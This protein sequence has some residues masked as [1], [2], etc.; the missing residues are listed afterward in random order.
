MLTN[1]GQHNLGNQSFIY[2]RCNTCNLEFPE[3]NLLIKCNGYNIYDCPWCSDDPPSNR[4]AYTL[5]DYF[6]MIKS[7]YEPKVREKTVHSSLR[8]IQS[9]AEI[10]F[11]VSDPKIGVLIRTGFSREKGR[12]VADLYYEFPILIS[13]GIGEVVELTELEDTLKSKLLEG[14]SI[15]RQ[16]GEELLQHAERLENEIFREDLIDSTVNEDLKDIEDSSGLMNKH[17]V[18]EEGD[19]IGDLEANYVPTVITA[20]RQSFISNKRAKDIPVIERTAKRRGRQ[21]DDWAD[22]E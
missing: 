4:A 8:L 21:A 3:I 15:C 12:I 1:I 14:A 22:L 7:K 17:Y 18:N 11:P 16:L 9:S 5:R 19:E 10:D 13:P 6:S 20:G 2:W